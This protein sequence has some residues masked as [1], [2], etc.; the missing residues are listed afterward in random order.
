MRAKPPDVF[1]LPDRPSFTGEGSDSA[2]YAW[3]VW[4]STIRAAR[5][6]VLKATPLAERKQDCGHAVMI[7]PRQRE[8]F[9]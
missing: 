9:G 6:Q 3:F 7:D 2:D 5:F 1:V 4:P 8:L